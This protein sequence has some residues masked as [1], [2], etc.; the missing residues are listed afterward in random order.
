MDDL[1]KAYLLKDKVGE[2][3][4]ATISS[5]TNF[6][7]FVALDNTAEGLVRIEALPDDTYLFLEKQ[8]KLK[9]ASNVFSI[10]DR[11]KVELINVNLYSR[12]IDFKMV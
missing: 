8:L 2:V 12:E 10:G 9:G 5:M 11:V 7:V 4:D 6:G 1:W 3:F